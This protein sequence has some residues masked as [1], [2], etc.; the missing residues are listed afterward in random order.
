MRLCFWVS[1]C[2]ALVAGCDEPA[3]T[4][5][6]ADAD[7]DADWEVAPPSEPERTPDLPRLRSW[8]CRDG[9][10]PV[11]SENVLDETG[12]PFTW[13]EP[14]PIPRLSL[15]G[16]VTPLEEGE[17]EGER[18]TC[19][20]AVDG[21]YPIVGFSEC[22]P[23]GDPCPE[24]PFPAIPAEVTGARWYVLAGATG[25]DGSE[26]A[27]YGTISEAVAAARNGDVVVIGARTYEESVSLD[28][29]VTLWGACVKETTISAPGPTRDPDT[30][31]AAAV[32]VE[33]GVVATVR[34]VR[35]SGEQ[36][37][38]VAYGEATLR[39]V[40]VHDT[41]L[42]GIVVS[43]GR[44]VLDHSLVT[45]TGRYGHCGCF[46]ASVDLCYAD[47]VEASL[48]ASASTIERSP[49]S[50]LALCGPSSDAAL[51]DVLIRTVR[52]TG[53][54]CQNGAVVFW[55]P[56]SLRARG[57]VVTDARPVGLALRGQGST[58]ELEDLLV[59]G[60]RPLGADFASGLFHDCGALQL[61]RGVIRENEGIPIA[62]SVQMSMQVGESTAHIEDLVVLDTPCVSGSMGFQ[63]FD[64]ADLTLDRALISDAASGLYLGEVAIPGSTTRADIRDLVMTDPVR[65][66]G[67][68]GNGIQV[69]VSSEADVALTRVLVDENNGTG[70]DV[71]G[72]GASAAVEDLTIT[73]SRAHDDAN[74]FAGGAFATSLGHLDLTR[75]RIED[76]PWVG[77]AAF[78]P[79]AVVEAR[80]LWVERTQPLLCDDCDPR[81]LLAS[82]GG[83]LRATRVIVDE[84]FLVGAM[85]T[86]AGSTLTL[87]D[88]Q[89]LRST[90]DATTGAFG[91]GLVVDDEASATIDGGL[92]G[93]NH[94]RGVHVLGEA[95][96]SLT[97]VSIRD[98]ASSDYDGR[99]GHGLY[100]EGGGSVS[101][102]HSE[103]SGNHDVS[104]AAFEEGTSVTLRDVRIGDSLERACLGLPEEDPNS[105][106]A[107][108]G[109]GLGAY[110]GAS[111]TIED[112][113]VS[114][115]ASIGVQV[116]EST[117][118]GSG[119]LVRDC[120]VA[121][122]LQSVPDDYDF[123]TEVTGLEFDGNGVQ[124]DE[125]EMSVPERP[126][127]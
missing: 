23:L 62:T 73:R 107:G 116:F 124:F 43:D 42:E 54:E 88:V 40:W 50:A 45:S 17:A 127:N 24:G 65:C 97:D 34:N 76:C 52:P 77:L 94:E 106:H 48:E 87:E 41:A 8:E 115:A 78:G 57:L 83:T 105:C 109:Y 30:D 13:C 6:D 103:L 35:L 92:I 85:A 47:A 68:A 26:G 28:R 111:V 64:G 80:D 74:S 20:P 59:S 3:I 108:R 110:D 96:L 72:D 89:I 114:R 49:D 84:N 32:R 91:L 71:A 66:D 11:A 15:D 70:L 10:Q 125:S 120:P 123:E 112:V 39:G 56:G 2:S 46:C 113:V 86:G 44:V 118:T 61:K 36:N 51:D 29:D 14:L 22:Q 25:G 21:T 33:E 79:G 9:W 16:S 82:Q 126:A 98:T 90:P 104:L 69:W 37:G 100:V 55:G 93:G 27:P 75:A 58:I 95:S 38:L 5:A 119:L 12:A 101:V 53:G 60:T 63:V 1:L 121:V 18:P 31:G 99:F 67:L 122:N 19:D 4:G 102:E 81:A 7:A 117:V